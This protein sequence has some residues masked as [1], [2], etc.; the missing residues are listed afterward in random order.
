MQ[1]VNVN[2]IDLAY[3]R[4]GSGTPLVLLH[5]YP[6]DGSIWSEVVPLLQDRFDLIIPDMRGFGESSREVAP[7]SLDDYASDIV[8][9]LD[10]LNIEKT[11]IAGHSMGGYVALAF[12][13]LYPERV[14]ALGLVASQAAA[15]TSERKQGR[16][17]T[18]A[19]IAEKGI[20]VVVESMTPKLTADERLRPLVQSIIEQQRP[21][22][23][24][25]AMRAMA[26]RINASAMLYTFRFPVVVIHGDAD[27]LIPIERAREVKNAVAHARFFEIK[28]AGHMPMMEFPAETAKAL[29]YLR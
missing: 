27:A 20:S 13:R 26:E 18:A 8:G 1:K 9:L 16:Y 25:D 5:G 10:R 14:S 6:L 29:S 28:G 2:G 22:G 15:D 12:A 19:Q 23:M 11:A 3:T 4:H 21:E 7:H 24:S 17:D